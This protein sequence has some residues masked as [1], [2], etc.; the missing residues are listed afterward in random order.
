ME[1]YLSEPRKSHTPT[2]SDYVEFASQPASPE[3]ET[4]IEALKAEHEQSPFLAENP[5]ANVPRAIQTAREMGL[6][7]A[8]TQYRGLVDMPGL[9]IAEHEWV[10][11]H[12]MVIDPSYPLHN[13][14]FSRELPLFI[15]NNR[16]LGN[17]NHIARNCEFEERICGNI[18]PWAR[19]L[20]KVVVIS[21]KTPA[22]PER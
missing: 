20:G 14:I 12:G 22:T 19:Y 21:N 1:R 7:N 13:E 2:Y 6:E 15:A 9:T 17:L 4:L 11:Y 5:A 18:P 3:T 8:I 16:A 10:S